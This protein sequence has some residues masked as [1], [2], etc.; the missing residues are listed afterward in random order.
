MKVL[1][2]GGTGFLGSHLAK[3][4]KRKN[5]IKIMARKMES[6]Y[7]TKD[8]LNT[9]DFVQCDIRNRNSIKRSLSSDIDLVIHCAGLINIRKD[10][11]CSPN[12]IE[13]NLN[14]T[15]NLIESMIDRG[16]KKILFCSSMTVYGAKNKIPVKEN[17]ILN[18]IHFYGHSKKW[19]EEA[20]K[21]YAQQGLIKALIV[22]YP[23]LYGY[24]RKTGYIYNVSRKILHKEKVNIITTG[25]KFWETMNIADAA[26]IT[27]KILKRF[28]GNRNY[29]ILNCSYG[30]EIDII[31]T[32][33]KIRDFYN[34]K[35]PIN[36]KKPVDYVKYYLDNTELKKRVYFNYNF[37]KSLK[38]FLSTYK[39]W[40]QE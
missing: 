20:I 10:G 12:L 38:K 2:T 34:S 32:A 37:E 28:K 33:F 39:N 22:R 3:Q 11:R 4:F 19:A 27:K 5:A 40:L 29:E 6:N 14:A 24:P 8:Q 35:V 13:T 23:G 18:P 1:I 15:I 9:Y 17:S 16:I 30:E 25:L 31:D 36:V 26:V 21:F 7:L